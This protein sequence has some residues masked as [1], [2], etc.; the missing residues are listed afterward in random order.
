MKAKALTSGVL[1]ARLPAELGRKYPVLVTMAKRGDRLATVLNCYRV[2]VGD[3]AW[4]EHGYDTNL[5]AWLGAF[6]ERTST[7]SA[8][9]ARLNAAGS[10]NLIGSGQSIRPHTMYYT[11]RPVY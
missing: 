9:G 7:A 3:D 1:E 10:D 2:V 4:F 11:Q 6:G 8:G 5:Y